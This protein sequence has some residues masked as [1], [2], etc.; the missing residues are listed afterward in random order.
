MV[1]TT[2]SQLERE[3][4]DTTVLMQRTDELARV[5]RWV[6]GDLGGGVGDWAGDPGY[7]AIL[8]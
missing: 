6:V 5:R 8:L 4:Q 2:A 3:K 1:S 7:L